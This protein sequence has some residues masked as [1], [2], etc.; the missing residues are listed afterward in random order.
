M[1]IQFPF[2]LKQFLILKIVITKQNFTEAASFLYISQP[3]I[4]KQLKKLEKD[5]DMI[6]LKFKNKNL[7]LTKTG[8]IVFQYVERILYICEE[9]YRI[10]KEL[11]TGLEA[12]KA[13][14][15][16]TLAKYQEDHK[17]LLQLD[18]L[19][20]IPNYEY[21]ESLHALFGKV[22]GLRYIRL[23]N[24]F[25]EDLKATGLQIIQDE[26]IRS[27]IVSLFENNYNLLE[28]YLA[29]ERSVNEVTRPY[30]LENFTNL[31]FHDSATPLDFK[32]IWSDPVYQNI[33]HYRIITL[34]FNQLTE[35]A[36]T[37]NTINNLVTSIDRY[38][39]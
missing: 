10:L 35:Y 31:D 7:V 25:Y 13:L 27:E 6:F 16:T 2:T 24:A 18:S 38:I 34:E 23:N 5:C 14:L 9:S 22:Y 30:Y 26:G 4:S 29:N 36:N 15:K 20:K 1:Y 39:N 8:Q 21:H 28:N 11:K 37:I 32:K 19:I 3:A 33:V 17:L 12:D